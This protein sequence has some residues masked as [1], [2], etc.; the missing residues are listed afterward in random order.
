MIPPSHRYVEYRLWLRSIITFDVHDIDTH[1]A[2][3]HVHVHVDPRLVRWI[4]IG[5]YIGDIDVIVT[6]HNQQTHRRVW[7]PDF[8][9]LAPA[10]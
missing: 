3:A 4:L 10:R 6:C 2:H 7:G 5:S 9:V 8:K 1:H